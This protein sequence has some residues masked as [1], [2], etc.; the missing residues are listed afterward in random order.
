MLP[1][2]SNIKPSKSAFISLKGKNSSNNQHFEQQNEN[3]LLNT[4]FD[5]D[6][7]KNTTENRPQKSSNIPKKSGLSSQ[8]SGIVSMMP[9]IIPKK[10][11]ISPQKSVQLKGHE[12]KNSFNS[13]KI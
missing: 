3:S 6:L 10:A 2:K 11:S 4:N 13:D 12:K 9:D 8:K 1:E 5:D 7:N